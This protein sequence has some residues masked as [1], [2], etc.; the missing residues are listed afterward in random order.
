[1]P[2]KEEYARLKADPLRW[3]RL[4]ETRAAHFAKK[5]AEIKS[6]PEKYRAFLDHKN[7]WMRNARK[8]PKTR[9]KIVAKDRRKYLRDKQIPERYE[10]NKKRWAEKE[11]RK[12][13]RNA[14]QLRAYWRA[15]RQLRK[16][17]QTKIDSRHK[18]YLLVLKQ[19]PTSL[20]A[21]VRDDVVSAILLAVLEGDIT[22]R[23]ISSSVKTYITK[24]YRMFNPYK[25]VSLDAPVPGASNLCY[26]DLLSNEDEHY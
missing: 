19:V 25:N 22:Q 23:Q 24:H 18:L 9:G 21:D 3:K 13:A 7:Q 20:P 17:K 26:V 8:N 2:T 5:Y 4:Q 12:R 16:E 15:R 10:R 1:M 6:D 14:E 11:R